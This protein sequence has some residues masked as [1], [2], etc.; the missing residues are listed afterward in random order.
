MS[1]LLCELDNGILRVTLNRPDD[2]NAANGRHGR[3]SDGGAQY[4]T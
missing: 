3:G 1:D 4:R 2:G